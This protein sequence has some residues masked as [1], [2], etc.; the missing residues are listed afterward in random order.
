MSKPPNPN[1]R[2][3]A[4]N[5]GEFPDRVLDRSRLDQ[6][7]YRRSGDE[8]HRDSRS[9]VFY[10]KASLYKSVRVRPK[11]KV[12]V[13]IPEPRQG[14]RT[15]IGPLG[16]QSKPL[17]KQ[18]SGLVLSNLNRL[19]RHR[20]EWGYRILQYLQTALIGTLHKVKSLSLAMAPYVRMSCR[21]MMVYKKPSFN[22]IR[23]FLSDYLKDCTET[24]LNWRELFRIVDP[25]QLL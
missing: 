7:A 11:H 25:V 15:N 24:S 3:Q 9:K 16:K 20:T 23:H 2:Y 21:W 17:N 19:F 10:Q 6:P 4:I 18:L 1:R 22:A 13:D 8:S 12:K 5:S 14:T